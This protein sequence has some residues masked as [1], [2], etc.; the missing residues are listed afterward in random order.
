MLGSLLKFELKYHFGQLSF[1]IAAVLFMVLGWF[2]AVQG[3]FGGSEIHKNAPYVI[4]NIVALFSLLSIFAGTLFAANVVL[5]DVIYKMDSVIFT[6]SVKRLPYFVVRFVGLLIA[7]FSLMVFT[8]IGIWLGSFFVDPSRLGAFNIVHY[9]QPLLVFGFP[10]VLFATS[11]IFCTAIVTKNV[12]AIYAAGVL[13]YILY[14]VASILGN[15]PLLATSAKTNDPSLLPFLI[16]SFGL[17][18]FFSETRNWS[19]LQRNQQLFP[20]K[21]VFLANRVL[22][23][24]FSGLVI[25][26]SYRLFNFRLQSQAQAK[27]K[28]K[29][30]KEVKLIPFRNIKVSPSGL[31]YNWAAF[32]SQFKLEAIS[33]FKH[34]PFMVM[35]LLWI[36]FFTVELK[37]SILHGPYGI[38]YLP[39]TAAIIEEI[40]SLKIALI[41]LIFYAAELIARERTSNMQGLIYSTPVRNSVLWGAKCLTLGLLV[42]VLVTVNIGIGITLQVF[43]G[44]FDIQIGKYLSLYYYSAFPLFLFIVLIVFVQNLMA[45]KYVGMMLSMIIVFLFMFAPRVGIEH[46]LLRFAAVPDLQF[47]FFNNFGHYAGAFNWYML[48]WTG[49]AMLLAALT[50][51]M[52][53]SSIQRTFVDRLKAIP[54]S[55]SQSKFVVLAGLIIWI[56]CGAFIYQQTNIIGKYQNKQTALDW[57]IGYEKKYK[58]MAELPQP[59]VKK[60]KTEVDLFTDEGKYQ[61]KGS[62][63]LKNET[64][65]AISKLW[66]SMHQAVTS[67]DIKVGDANK[68]ET[69][70]TYNQQFMEL[71]NP[72]QPGAEMKLD[73]SFEVVRSGFVPFDSENSVVTNGTYI[74]MEKFVPRF[75]YNPGLEIDD[76][77]TRKAAGLPPFSLSVSTD[78]NYHL[79]ELETTISTAADQQ[80]V[81][82]G[83]L[84]KSWT[85]NNRRYFTY[86]TP[87]PVRFMFALSSAR[88][89]VKT[90]VANGVTLKVYYLKGHEY[91]IKT[92]LKGMKDALAY[93]S[94][95][96]SPYPLK[97]LSLAEIPQYKGAATAYMG[98]VF[99]AE[100]INYLTDY[101]NENL[102]NQSYAITAH[103]VGHQWWAN[104]VAPVDGPGAAMLTESLA[105]YTEAILLEKQYGKMYLRN[106]LKDDNNLYFV[107]RDVNQKEFPLAQT[108]QENNVHYQKGGLVM[109]AT[110]EILGEEAVNQTLRKLIAQHASPNVKPKT[111]DLIEPLLQLA[112][113]NQKQFINESFNQVVTYEI[114]V[115]V[116]A[117][118]AI[119]NG[120]FKVE[121]EVNAGVNKQGVNKL[122][123]PAMDIDLAFFDQ[124]A[125]TWNR[126]TQPIYLQKI[127]F[128]QLTTKL[129]I[130][131]AKK[132]KA[133][134]ID[135]YVYLLD[136][137]QSDNVQVIK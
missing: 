113:A 134:A 49:F 130:V 77:R 118:K 117:C 116:L 32:R 89:E 11:L 70:L 47:S 15:S 63:L 52:W 45:N 108:Y 99:N 8:V 92:M 127:R 16:D 27:Q 135:P 6:T 72:L 69:D 33:L 22:W 34:I 125:E 107:Y 66:I 43:N 4:T 51:G 75:G 2:S 1:I 101:S 64:S 114:G 115:K 3:G 60:I 133:V 104:K 79:I 129:S 39:T 65:Q 109:Y 10:N 91:N 62:Y 81:T 57:R 94:A 106:Y 124:A 58:A 42:V 97:E 80:V 86:Q 24:L 36:F 76:E 68:Q 40:R 14:M 67:F 38:K 83:T 59:M 88:Y 123:P 111:I 74:E 128:D 37:D 56:C 35:L 26:I 102:V 41:L 50:I 31:A 29:S 48:Y 132:P 28:N 105:K 54:R 96:F 19:D 71:K 93:G 131:V 17:A 120:Q 73:F 90:E 84:Q 7:V 9:L 103:E 5:R 122:L 82:V 98:V 55:I 100:K 85:A 18:S 23:L 119:A 21:E 44:Y 20:V 12:R 87:V 136:P 126:N 53:Q 61:V 78:R 112:P 137:D 110:K 121:L 25:I 30:Q 46:F 13:L 95:N